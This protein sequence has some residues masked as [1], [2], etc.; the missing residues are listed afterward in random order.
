MATGRRHTASERGPKSR[1]WTATALAAI[2][3]FGLFLFAGASEWATRA[4]SAAAFATA[5]ALLIGIGIDA[6]IDRRR[7]AARRREL[8]SA[9]PDWATREREASHGRAHRRRGNQEAVGYDDTD[10]DVAQYIGAEVYEREYQ[11]SVDRWQRDKQSEL[12]IRTLLAGAAAVFGAIGTLLTLTPERVLLVTVVE[13]MWPVAIAVSMATVATVEL[14]AR[15]SAWIRLDY[16]WKTWANE[17]GNASANLVAVKPEPA[18]ILT[19]SPP[20]PPP[21]PAPPPSPPPAPP[22]SP[23]PAPPPPPPAPPRTKLPAIFGDD[24]R[25]RLPNENDDRAGN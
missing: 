20:L 9:R 22:P 19:P 8:H 11:A 12:R 4:I 24:Y 1:L 7:L 17:G 23:P 16:E 6:W 14:L 25:P 10:G 15:S 18:I 21:P 2:P 3:A 5:F 13:L